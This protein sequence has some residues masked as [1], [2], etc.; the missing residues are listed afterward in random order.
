MANLWFYLDDED[1]EDE[2][3]EKDEPIVEP[4]DLLEDEDIYCKQ[5]GALVEDGFQCE[6]CGWMVEII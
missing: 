6:I 2:I 3:Y 5:C 1:E 4:V